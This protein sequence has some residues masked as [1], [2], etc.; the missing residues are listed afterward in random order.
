MVNHLPL[1]CDLQPSAH[2]FIL[3]SHAGLFYA[4]IHRQYGLLLIE[5]TITG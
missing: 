1:G 4:Q 5:I 3:T 2:V